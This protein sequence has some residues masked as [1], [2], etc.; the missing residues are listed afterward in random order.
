M[1]WEGSETWAGGAL[2]YGHFPNTI[3]TPLRN[4]DVVNGKNKTKLI[5]GHFPNAS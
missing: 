1:T 5:Y 4:K 2:I 3:S